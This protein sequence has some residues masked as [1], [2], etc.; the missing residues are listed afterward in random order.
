M[1]I[2]MISVTVAIAWAGQS[3]AQKLSAYTGHIKKIGAVVLIIVGIWFVR[4]YFITYLF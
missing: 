2:L 1:V 4:E 3:A